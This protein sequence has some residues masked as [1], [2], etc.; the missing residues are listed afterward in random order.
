MTSDEVLLGTVLDADTDPV[1][2]YADADGTVVLRWEY[3][4]DMVFGRTGRDKLA[5]CSTGP[6][7]RGSA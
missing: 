6:R 2:V 5:S 7:C 3:G 4:T 1:E